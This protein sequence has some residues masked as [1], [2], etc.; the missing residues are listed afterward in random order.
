[1]TPDPR[2]RWKKKRWRAAA[3]ALLLIAYPA[4]AGPY[5]YA[6][7]LGVVPP[8]AQVPIGYCHLPLIAISGIAWPEG[9]LFDAYLNWWADLGERHAAAL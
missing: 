1:M 4:S 7:S 9:K 6:K 2:P 8:A 5:A 3:A